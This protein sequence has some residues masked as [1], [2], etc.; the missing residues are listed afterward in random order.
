MSRYAQYTK[1]PVAQSIG[2]IEKELNRYGAD[3][4]TYGWDEGR[5][6][7]GFR[8]QGRMVK[9]LIDLPE[10]EQGQR[11]IWRAMLLMV[12]SKLECIETGIETFEEAFLAHIVVPGRGA[13]FGQLMIPELTRAIETGDLPKLLE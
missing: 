1:V 9:F 2:H 4:F 12:K 10:T 6:M 7:I 13:T 11:Q 5:A 8:F 3:G